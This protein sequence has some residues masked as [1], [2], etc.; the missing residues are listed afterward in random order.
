M[1]DKIIALRNKIHENEFRFVLTPQH[2]K[3]LY[4]PENEDAHLV[5]VSRDGELAGYA[6]FYVV[7]FGDIR[8][9]DVSEI[10]AA[11]KGILTELIDQ[12]VERS[13]KDSVDFV[14]LQ[15]C[16]EPYD[17][18]LR[19]RGFLSFTERAILTALLDPR[20]LLSTL[21]ERVDNGPVLEVA[22]TGFDPILV[23][24]GRAGIALVVDKEPDLSIST[25]SKTWLRLLF[26]RTSFLKQFFMRRITI[27][28]MSKLVSAVR[29]FNIIRQDK[30]YLPMA[31][32]T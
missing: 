7:E 14:F 28:D 17:E 12:I 10:C 3:A 6:T 9:Y 25:D 16:E 27:S 2:W 19:Q 21:S 23:Q 18:I 22:I 26:G 32:W 1:I 24:V 20:T 4:V 11:D 13:M 5:T 29:F 8:A 31:D 30:M 15:T